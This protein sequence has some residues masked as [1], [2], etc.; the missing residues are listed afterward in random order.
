MKIDIRGRVDNLRLAASHGLRPVF[1]A[2]ANSVH[3]IEDRQDREEVEGQIEIVVYRD[4]GQEVL[5][6]DKRKS[7]PI[8]EFEVSDNGIGFDETNF[9][10]FE[11]SDS[12]HKVARGGKG[13]GRLLWLIAFDRAV[14]QSVF[15]DAAGNLKRRSFKFTYSERGTQ[16]S[17]LEDALGSTVGTTIKL[18]GFKSKFRDACVKS[19]ESLAQRI[20]EH[21]LEF[22]AMP[23]APSMVLRDATT[24][25]SID[26]NS[27]F[28]EHFRTSQDDFE[29]GGQRF[30]LTHVMSSPR[31]NE[32][33]TVNYCA[34]N[35]AVVTDALS[36]DVP[37]L[38]TSLHD[39][40]RDRKF[41]YSGYLSSP[42]LDERVLPE[43]TR[44][45]F[46]EPGQLVADSELRWERV[47]SA[48][49]ERVTRYLSVYTEKIRAEKEDR[50][51]EFVET[52]APQYRPLLKHR[53]FAIDDIPV[54]I[55]DDRLD[56]ELYKRNQKYDLELQEQYHEIL[57]D[58]VSMDGFN[59]F[60]SQYD[61]F[62]QQWNER[63]DSEL[64]R[65]V[66][67]RKATL[68]FLRTRLRRGSD[69]KYQLEDAIHEVVFPMR[70]ETSDVPEDRTN[71]WI[72]DE[73]LAYHH[74][75]ASD[76]QLR[77]MKKTIKSN[78]QKEPDIVIFNRPFAFSEGEGVRYD[79]LVVV[80]FK[81]P[82]RDD[83]A[84]DDN[85]IEQVIGY[86]K[87]IRNGDALDK[88]GRPI[89]FPA[90][91]PIHAIIVCDFT[92]KL[93]EQANDSNFKRTADQDR[94]FFFHD[95]HGAYFEIMS[96]D[97]MMDLAERRNRILFDKLG[98]KAGAGLPAIAA[99][100]PNA[101]SNGQV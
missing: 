84:A 20:I 11:T 38:D 80:E 100:T 19:L 8:S 93:I 76:K 34:H 24:G 96:F 14:V 42:A 99:D 27:V 67:H 90:G 68:D 41:I 77:S 73:T 87:E 64:A 61:E 21:C 70:A 6:Q 55:P 89:R 95:N 63:G 28:A 23:S 53:P 16:D 101:W 1:E 60:A 69:G 29:I 81:R 74:Y 46:P 2:I 7:D 71:L 56:V 48:T 45:E 3:A 4:T 57:G 31:P 75:L 66:V 9:E 52:I 54:N 59:A 86:I 83:Y 30:R 51:L 58:R 78:S 92:P 98:L 91:M 36:N 37:N 33:H 85:P 47:K 50:I 97:V 26:L 49:I 35:R 94:Y 18:I 82:L 44:F 13:I 10:S 32:T 40:E 62:W 72:L 5:H 88:H 25:Q 79:S 43:R 39:E 15:S 65:Y 17:R 22:L 12:R